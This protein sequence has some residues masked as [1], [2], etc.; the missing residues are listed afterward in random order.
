MSNAMSR[1]YLDGVAKKYCV[2]E[3]ILKRGDGLG[4]LDVEMLARLGRSARVFFGDP[5]RC[6]KPSRPRHT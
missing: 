6:V 1:R 5:Y 2:F 3:A 4:M